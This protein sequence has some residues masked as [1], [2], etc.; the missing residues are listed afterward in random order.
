MAKV[1]KRALLI[2]IKGYSSFE[3]VDTET[4]LLDN[5]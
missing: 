2:L 5:V 3:I 1:A 4:R